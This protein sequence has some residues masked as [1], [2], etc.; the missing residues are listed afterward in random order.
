MGAV[1]ALACD[2]PPFADRALA[3]LRDWPALR[4]LPAE[5]GGVG[6]AAGA[7]QVVHLHRGHEAEV[8]LSKPAICRMRAA[9]ADSPQVRFAAGGDWVRVGLRSDCDVALL[10][11]LVSVA[12]AAHAAGRRVTPW[13]R[14]APCPASV[15]TRGMLATAR[16]A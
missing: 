9:L 3:R 7:R 16:S 4:V 10:E 8:Y 1:E 14:V 11:S 15:R 12:I 2:A 5:G 6:L 13:H